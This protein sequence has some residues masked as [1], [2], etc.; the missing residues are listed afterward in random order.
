MVAVDVD[1]AFVVPGL[2]LQGCGDR[3]HLGRA[4]LKLPEEMQSG[5]GRALERRNSAFEEGRGQVK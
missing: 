5:V 4:R 3:G 2:P 1:V